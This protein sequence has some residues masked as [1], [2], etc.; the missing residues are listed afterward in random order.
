MSTRLDSPLFE[1]P[2]AGTVAIEASAGTGKTWMIVG[3]YLRLLVERRLEPRDILVVTFTNAATAELRARIRKELLALRSALADESGPSALIEELCARITDRA[4]LMRRI[5]LAVESFDEAAIHTIHGFCQRVLADHAFESAMPFESALQSNDAGVIDEVARDFWRRAVADA[6]GP[7]AQFLAQGGRGP[8]RLVEAGRDALRPGTVRMLA[9]Q[10]T[11]DDTKPFVQAFTTARRSWLTERERI[12][13]LLEGDA[14]SRTTYSLNAIAAWR[15]TLDVFFA[16]A[17]PVLPLPEGLAKLAASALAANTKVKKRPPSHAFFEAAERLWALGETLAG[18]HEARWAAL[19]ARFAAEAKADI[20]RRKLEEGWQSYDDLLSRLHAALESDAGAALSQSITA[21]FQAALID[22]FQDTDAVQYAIL[23]R[24]FVETGR[25]LLLV[26]DPKQAIYKFR[27]ADVYTYL[28]ARADADSRFG[29][30]V[31]RRSTPE[32]LR[33]INTL[34]DRAA[35]PFLVDEIAFARARPADT[36]SS[37]LLLEGDPAPC[38]LWYVPGSIKAPESKGDLRR[39]AAAATADE[40]RRLLERAAAGHATIVENGASRRVHGG[41]IAVL[42]RRHEEAAAVREALSLRGIPA[43]TFGQ[44]SVFESPE[45]AELAQ[46]LSAVAAPRDERLV[47]GALCTTLFGRTLDA[48]AALTEDAP[49]WDRELARFRALHDT[50]RAGGVV[51]LLR[52][53]VEQDRVPERLLGYADGDRRLTNFQHLAELLHGVAAT[54]SYDPA[55]LARYLRQAIGGSGIADE[56]E[57]IRLESDEQLVRVVTVHAAKG[58]EYPVVFCP[59]LW[60]GARRAAKEPPPVRFH[61]EQRALVLDFGSAALDQHRRQAAAEE[62]AEQLRLA[63]VALTRAKHRCYLIW[64]AARAAAS[65]A[66]AWLMHGPVEAV[67]DATSAQDTLIGRLSGL[68]AEQLRREVDAVAKRA[69]GSIE[70]VELP[71]PDE[72]VPMP[73]AWVRPT[74]RAQAFTG[75]VPLARRMSSFTALV[76]QSEADAPDHDA[77]VSAVPGDAEA[78]ADT[79]PADDILAFPRGAQAGSCLH[80][81]FERVVQHERLEEAALRGIARTQL[82]A[83]GLSPRLEAVASR[84]VQHTLGAPLD[85]AGVL[86]LSALPAESRITEVEFHYPIH[87]REAPILARALALHRREC[88]LAGLVD[89][90]DLSVA[91]GYMKGFIDL[92]FEHDGRYFLA[93]YKSNWLGP[94]LDHYRADSLAQAIVAEHYDLQY[95]LY[96][97]ALDRWLAG[98]LPGY[99]YDRHVGGVY[100]LFVRGIRRELGKERGVYIA[101]PSLAVIAML[102][103]LATS[104]EITA[105]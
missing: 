49:A 68:S 16:G 71:Y 90:L 17:A 11:G 54:Q 29:L 57:Q 45:A 92:A 77:F 75:S 22:E 86:R 15:E 97:L 31:N 5:A 82:I 32:L 100:Y 28:G 6:D 91:S 96:V 50:L 2:L 30:T 69:E 46:V 67:D 43:V 35:S 81:I 33:A 44:R 12:V 66:L 37:R 20:A 76:A 41:D 101:R 27:G 62:F 94:T 89:S 4:E 80:A 51:R 85:R 14:L 84:I 98:R 42:V 105:P 40:I 13:A 60:D 79:P 103:R 78:S 104:M 52:A 10:P 25:A 59:Y 47:R 88:G 19:V 1:I 38:V 83:Y 3:L 18:Q 56:E 58:L 65:S 53:I 72:Q 63:Y 73:D 74:G 39:R 7:W 95:L 55:G 48:L 61:D 64:G 23:R 8:A 93:D 34:F 99:D 36:D 70:I 87:A 9:P 21:R 102:R 24:L 26:G